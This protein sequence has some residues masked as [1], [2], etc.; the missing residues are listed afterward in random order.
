MAESNVNAAI[1]RLN[2]AFD[3][4][5]NR[6]D[7]AALGALYAEDAV[8]L[9]PGAP[10]QKGRAAIRAFWE[11]MFREFAN[12]HL[13]TVDLKPYGEN[14]LREIGRLTVEPKAAPGQKLAGKYIVIWENTGGEWKLATD[15][16]NFDSE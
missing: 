16:A 8:L 14:V 11:G 3:A 9:P 13:M 2:A 10:M 5:F 6:G 12:L 4:A 7:A 1:A 15:I